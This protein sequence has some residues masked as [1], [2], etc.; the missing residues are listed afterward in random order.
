MLNKKEEVHQILLPNTQIRAEKCRK[1]NKAMIFSVCPE[2][3]IPDQMLVLQERES[4]KTIK[5]FRTT[6]TL[7]I[8]AERYLME[9]PLET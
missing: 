4:I 7:L 2:E 8:G 3:M 5:L 6:E 1:I 9:E